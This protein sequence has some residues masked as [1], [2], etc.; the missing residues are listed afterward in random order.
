MSQKSNLFT[1]IEI[2]PYFSRNQINAN[3]KKFNISEANYNYHISRALRNKSIVRVKRDM[4]VTRESF[5]ANRTKTAFLFYLSNIALKPSYISLE[6]ALDYYGMFAEGIGENITAITT[7]TPRVF[8]S[9]VSRFSYR[10]IKAELF[11]DFQIL[12]IDGFEF[13]IA[14]KYKAVF[15]YLYYQT[16]Q[17]T[18]NLYPELIEDLRI[19]TSLLTKRELRKLTTILA[20]YTSVKFHL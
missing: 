18:K 7:K 6:T 17:F 15:D 14:K 4:Y 19:D 20:T 12:N 11:S 3:V 2:L 8:N 1:G 9:Q 16:D 5:M 13:A 10:K